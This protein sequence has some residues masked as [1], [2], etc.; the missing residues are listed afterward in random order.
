M[1]FIHAQPKKKNAF[2]DV[3]TKSNEKLSESSGYFREKF[4]AKK[5]F[6]FV[7]KKKKK[8]YLMVSLQR[9]SEE[10]KGDDFNFLVSMKNEI[11]SSL[12]SC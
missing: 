5:I 9:T 1:F 12:R 7:S 10:N 8:N 3:Q 2:G 6:I 4:S 11:L